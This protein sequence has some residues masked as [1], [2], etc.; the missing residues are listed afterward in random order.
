MYKLGLEK[1]KEPEKARKFQKNIYF[2]FTD[3]IKAVDF[4][5]NN[6]QWKILQKTGIP[7]PVS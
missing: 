2:C 3:F 6:K 5:D 7:V 1:A 4:V